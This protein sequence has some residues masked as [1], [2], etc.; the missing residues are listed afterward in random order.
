MTTITVRG[1]RLFPSS[2]LFYI[3]G[4]CVMESPR[5]V[6]EH[7]GAIRTAC[8]RVGVP[9]V[10]KA[11]FDKAN[12][13]SIDSYRGPGLAA[14]L[15]ILREVRR[16]FPDLPLLTDIHEPAQAEPVAEVVDILQIPAF[17][18]RQTDLVVAAAR[19]GRPV[20]IKK[21]QFMDPR[22]MEHI[23][24]KAISAGNSKI[25]LT[26]RGITFGYGN[27]VADMR[28]IPIMRRFG[29]PVVFDAGHSVQ[30]P[31]AAGGA[32]GGQREMIPVLARAAVAAGADGVFI[33]THADPEHA[34][35]DAQ[36]M[37]PLRELPG[38]LR[39]LAAVRKVVH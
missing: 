38:L 27:L 3:G 26:D 16:R 4:P 13:M 14:G 19:T 37:L 10:F 35:S 39:T 34:K 1:V 21:G 33:E 7:A 5:M 12:R 18:C 23:A 24:K 15:E 17:L 29:Y 9:C 2:R 20:N 6:L 31:G 32:S 8:R 11:S 22:A 25:I 30:F 28:A 36:S